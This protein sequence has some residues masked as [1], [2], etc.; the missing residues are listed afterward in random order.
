M[1]VEGQSESILRTNWTFNEKRR[2]GTT[3]IVRRLKISEDAQCI[4]KL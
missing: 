3:K 2:K 1:K 4:V